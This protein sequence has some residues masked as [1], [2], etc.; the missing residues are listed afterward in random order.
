[1][2]ERVLISTGLVTQTHRVLHLSQGNGLS[3]PIVICIEK[4]S[5]HGLP[6]SW[7]MRRDGVVAQ[8]PMALLRLKNL[9]RILQLRKSRQFSGQCDDKSRVPGTDRCL[10]SVAESG[11]DHVGGRWRLLGLNTFPGSTQ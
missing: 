3:A 5:R 9:L 1:M 7:V 2:C 11:V 8:V 10:P 4:D 6:M